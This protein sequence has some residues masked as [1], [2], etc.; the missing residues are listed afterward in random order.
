MKSQEKQNKIKDDLL[1]VK[2]LREGMKP[3]VVNEDLI[4]RYIFY[5]V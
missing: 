5:F 2:P 1:Q 4:E 3:I